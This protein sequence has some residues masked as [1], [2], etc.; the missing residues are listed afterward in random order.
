MLTGLGGSVVYMMILGDDKPRWSFETEFKCSGFI[1]IMSFLMPGAF[2][3]DSLKFMRS[4]KE[5]A[6]SEYKGAA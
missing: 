5:F 1:R 2:R 3:K 6:E 4:F